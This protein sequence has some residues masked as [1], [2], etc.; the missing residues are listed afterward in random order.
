MT[1]SG[2]ERS[3]LLEI[4]LKILPKNMFSK[5]KISVM[6]S[7]KKINSKIFLVH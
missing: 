6:I 7:T 5:M 4:R 2:K 1:K 3:I